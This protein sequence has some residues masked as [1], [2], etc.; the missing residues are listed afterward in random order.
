MQ[1]LTVEINFKKEK[2]SFI[3]CYGENNNNSVRFDPIL[4]LHDLYDSRTNLLTAN[5]AVFNH[6]TEVEVR[7]GISFYVSG[8]I[9][10][11]CEG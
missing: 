4:Q 5:G 7:P 6:E 3:Q 9:L 2:R 10:N 11:N 1:I 8:I